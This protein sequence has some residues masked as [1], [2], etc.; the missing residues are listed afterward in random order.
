MTAVGTR[1]S[2]AESSDEDEEDESGDDDDDDDDDDD[3]DD[4]DDDDDSDDDGEESDD[5][6]N[7]VRTHI[8]KIFAMVEPNGLVKS[9][10]VDGQV[11]SQD[12][13]NNSS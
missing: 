7:N 3:E 2:N 9:E 10:I 8:L 1:G 13:A 4:E 12:Q 5:D 11:V 6:E